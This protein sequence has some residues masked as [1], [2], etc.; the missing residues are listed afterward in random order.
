MK[1]RIIFTGTG[2]IL[3]LATY[4][5]FDDTKLVEKLNIKGIKKFMAS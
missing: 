1:S 5:S 2:P 3:I 4:Q